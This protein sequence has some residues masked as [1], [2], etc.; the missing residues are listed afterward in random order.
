MLLCTRKPCYR[1][2]DRAMRPTYECPERFR[3]SLATPTATFPQNVNGLLLQSII[4][5]C[6]HNLKSVALSVP[7]I[8]GVP[9][10]CRQRLDTP[11]L[12]FLQNCSGLLFG[13][14]M[15]PVNVPDKFEVRS[16][17]RS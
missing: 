8:K 4:L 7:E 6:M 15:D 9:K 3:E 14:R 17:T 2:D 10:K 13:I 12:S 16:C 1:K 11:T 5:K